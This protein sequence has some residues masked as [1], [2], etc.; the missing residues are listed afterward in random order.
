MA[1]DLRTTERPASRVITPQVLYTAAHSGFSRD[2]PLGGGATICRQLIDAW[3][4][5]NPF[6]LTVLGPELLGRQ[7]PRDKDL[8]RFSESQYARFCLAFEKA[9]TEQILTH[10]PARTIVLSND[11]SEG[12]RFQLLAQKGY[13]L[14]VIYHVNV[15]DYFTA[16]YL[17]GSVKT[18]TA[19]RFYSR[20][21]DSPFHGLLPNIL[22]LAFAKQRDSLVY[23]RGV[24]VP[25]E[26]MKD[27]LLRSYPGVPAEK[28]HVLPWGLVPGQEEE[29]QIAEQAQALRVQYQI[30]EKTPVLLTLS[31]ISPEKG[32]DRLLE[33]LAWWEKQ[34]DFPAPGIQV[35]ICGEAAFMQGARHQKKL[36]KLAGRLKRTRVVFPGHVSGVLKQAFFR[37]A[38]LYVFPSRHES[39]GLTLLEALAAGLPV[40]ACRHYGAEE[41]VQPAF[42]ELLPACPESEMPRVL[43]G[44]LQRLLADPARLQ[45]M[46]VEGK[47]FAAKQDFSNTAARLAD[48]LTH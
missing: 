39:Y 37:L 45:A 26:G 9:L 3:Q 23:S 30:P 32:Q 5:T 14:Y 25:S 2:I 36:E 29:R 22:R 7:A 31:R 4:K 34:P 19:A 6:P 18:E 16:M 12:P 40:V 24:I 21:Q 11:V 43:A 27:V 10:D 15:V 41:L 44:A 20:I 28:I 13:R 46:G 35:F 1:S 47:R 38:N 8:V 33:A 48:I 17:H 42:G